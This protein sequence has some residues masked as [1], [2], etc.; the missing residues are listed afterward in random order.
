KEHINTLNQRSI[1]VS[2]EAANL[3][4]ALRNDKTM[5]GSW[6]EVI[7]ERLL[8]LSGLEKDRE[9][10]IQQ[11]IV[12]EDGNR[13]RPD[14]IL[15]LPDDKNIVIDSKVS[16]NAYNDYCNAKDE[17]TQAIFIKKHVKAIDTH[18]TTLSA[19]D[20]EKLPGVNSLDYTL[21]FFPLEAAFLAAQKEDPKLFERGIDK[22]IILVAPTTLLAT[23]KVIHNLWRNEKRVMNAQQI[24]TE[25]GKLYDKF[26]GFIEDM[27]K[28]GKSLDTA[29]QSFTGAQNKL[30]QGR[31]NLLGQADKM[32]ES[33]KGL[34]SGKSNKSSKQKDNESQED[35]ESIVGTIENMKSLGADA[36]KKIARQT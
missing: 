10:F 17:E 18:I 26:V 6:G 31:G 7:L 21:M 28:L 2:E 14:V 33:A 24:A 19:K 11:S 34:I 8:E 25:G 32:G 23:L 27:D 36:K 1:E 29:Q 20:Y 12:A 4:N 35:N 5:Q 30:H 3:T 9:Y 16:L 13:R 15:K 22:N